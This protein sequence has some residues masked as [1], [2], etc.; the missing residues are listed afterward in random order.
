MTKSH[1]QGHGVGEAL[2][3]GVGS[4]KGCMA[5]VFTSPHGGFH[6][7]LSACPYLFLVPGHAPSVVT[8]KLSIFA[9]PCQS[10]HICAKR[11]S[12]IGPHLVPLTQSIFSLHESMLSRR[13]LKAVLDMIS[14]FPK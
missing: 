2:E 4:L 13:S 14:R 10:M 9:T 6:F 8:S 1:T 3:I 11:S 5:G 7:L 12:P